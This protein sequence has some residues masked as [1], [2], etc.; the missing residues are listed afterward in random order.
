MNTQEILEKIGGNFEV[1]KR[2]SAYP[3]TSKDN[4]PYLYKNIRRYSTIVR[5]DN[6]IGL[7]VVG[8]DY[9]IVQYRDAISF[10]DQ[11]M[12]KK[13]IRFDSGWVIDGG[14]KLYI[15]LNGSEAINLGPNE[16]IQAAFMVSTTHDGTGAIR[17][18]ATPIYTPLKSIITPFGKA[19]IK[20]KHKS[21]V[22]QRINLSKMAIERL[23]NYFE[24][25]R[26]SF[27]D[28]TTVNVTEID[29]K[30]YFN[31]L[32]ESESTRAENIRNKL[33]DIFLTSPITSSLVSCKGTLFGCFMAVVQY[34]DLY[35]IVRKSKIRNPEEARVL[36]SLD[37][38]GAKMKADALSFA[39]RIMARGHFSL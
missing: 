12:D 26:D 35:K 34:A 32:I 13:S 22:E 14:A 19:Q 30:S 27:A 23:F 36:S 29:A 28:L 6:E 17:I 2:P 24:Q 25:N 31:S 37:G 16:A 18:S 15:L 11:V 21:R 10:L 33:Y 3:C 39:L 9:G 8:E 38:D 5:K 7:S 4:L 20:I 1:E